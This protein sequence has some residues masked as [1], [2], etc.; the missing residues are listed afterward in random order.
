MKRCYKMATDY[1]ALAKMTD[2]D[3]DCSDLPAF[4]KEWL[5]SIE[6]VV[7]YP[8][9]EPI[10]LRLDRRILD[11]F[12]STGKGY[13]RRINEVLKS[14]VKLAMKLKEGAQPQV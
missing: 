4:T 1:E 8:R 7:E 6:G 14:Y 5:D 13:Q 12:K 2:N 9:K 11:Y 10:S 3:I